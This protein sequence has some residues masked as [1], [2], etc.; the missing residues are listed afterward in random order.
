VPYYFNLPIITELTEHQQLAV[1]ETEPLALAGGPGTG[2][3]VVCLWRHIRNYAT[4]TRRSLLITYT[5]TLEHYLTGSATSEASNGADKHIGRAFQWLHGVKQHYDEIIIDEG[6]DL[7][8]ATFAQYFNYTP[9][10]SYGADPRQSVFL[11]E[12][13]QQVLF[14]WLDKDA[15]LDNNIPITL[16]KNFRNSQEILKFS[17]AMLPHF[18][19]PQ[20][21]IDSSRVSSLKPILKINVGFGVENQ[22][23]AIQEIIETFAGPAHNIG[24]LLPFQNKVMSYFSAIS[25][26]TAEKTKVTQYYSKMPNFKG[27][28]GVHV[29]TY[30]SSKGTE[31]DTVIIPEFENM[32]WILANRPVV[33]NN[34][35]YVAFTRAKA[36]LILLCTNGNP[37]YGDKSTYDTE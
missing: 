18:N 1:N 32:S 22:V 10:I 23:K 9:V 3:S 12:E 33:T 5:K 7:E 14:D 8:Q 30:K 24:V 34:D 11:K 28:E 13:Q 27:M 26:R 36:N 16:H 21:T 35:Y 6:Q 4:G 29:T 25:A 19:I 20:R 31:F 2:K 37:G 15:R 17:R